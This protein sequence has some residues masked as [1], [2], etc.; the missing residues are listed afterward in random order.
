MSF[1]LSSIFDNNIYTFVGQP[2]FFLFLF[3]LDLSTLYEREL[4][5]ACKKKGLVF[6]PL[7]D[8]FEI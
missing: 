8:R 7:F 4:H 6:E 3:E 5:N 1:S 2:F